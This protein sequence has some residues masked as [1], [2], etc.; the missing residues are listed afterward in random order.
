MVEPNCLSLES[1]EGFR[2]LKVAESKAILLCAVSAIDIS[3]ALRLRERAAAGSWVIWESSPF[4]CKSQDRI[5]RDVF[6]IT[7]KK[8]VV[9]LPDHM[10]STGSYVRYRW[11][12]LAL[13]RTF[14][15]LVPVLS[16]EAET[17][18]FYGDTP[19]AMKRSIGR[20]GLLFLGSML[21]PHLR[22]EDPDA[23]AIG[24]AML[25][26]LASDLHSVTFT[27]FQD[28]AVGDKGFEAR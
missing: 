13:T 18:A 4:A 17:V 19:V 26:A 6:G 7:T 11:P 25:C 12:H 24:T 22:A 5:L 20:G 2:S 28:R 10:E 27:R 16:P 21:G 1:A 3:L 8:P 9:L 14:S 23:R 15:A